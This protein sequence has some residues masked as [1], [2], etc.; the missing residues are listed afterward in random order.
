M[1]TI[2]L[3]LLGIALRF[4]PHAPNFTPVVA[5]ALFSGFYL[6]RKYAVLV[7]LL[8]M[9]ITDLFLGFHEIIAFTWG[10]IVLITIFGIIQKKRKSVL[11]IVSSSLISATLFFLVT[12]FGVWLAGWYTYTFEGLMKCYIMAIPFFRNMIFSTLLYSVAL[13][14]LYDLIA[15]RVRDTRFASVLLTN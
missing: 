4:I 2:I 9:V 3:I 12:N 15:N 10:S 6:K 1:L 5:I 11:T 7:P 13:F 14:G 8:L